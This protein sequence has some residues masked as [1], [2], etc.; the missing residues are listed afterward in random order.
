MHFHTNKSWRLAI[1]MFSAIATELYV[2]LF[3]LGVIS[4]EIDSK[5]LVIA[6]FI[7]QM[8]VYLVTVACVGLF[9]AVFSSK[10]FWVK[11]KNDTSL[12]VL[13]V[14]LMFFMGWFNFQNSSN[15]GSV[16][17]FFE[18]V[19]SPLF[20]DVRLLVLT[21]LATIVSLVIFFV[22]GHSMDKETFHKIYYV[23]NLHGLLKA[24]LGMVLFILF[25][26]TTLTP[27]IFA[28]LDTN[29]HSILVLIFISLIFGDATV[30][31][32]KY[33]TKFLLKEK[34]M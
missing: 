4:L 12:G 8:A 6:Y 30:E 23:T 21:G 33:K 25:Y 11:F 5:S 29:M 9:T 19:V 10:K 26:V 17:N 20:Y 14:G 31:Y 3:L 7:A 15:D 32:K 18:L 22:F 1:L 16:S 13:A 2:L 28:F 34:T 24:A 27:D